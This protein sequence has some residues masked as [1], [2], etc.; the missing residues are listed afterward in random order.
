MS[1]FIHLLETFLGIEPYFNL[2]RSLFFVKPEPNNS[3]IAKVGG[4]D[5]QLRLGMED[6]YIPYKL[7]TSL[8]G[9]RD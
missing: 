9:W 3:N 8:P 7:P 1:I 6:R 2:L 5:L 4:A